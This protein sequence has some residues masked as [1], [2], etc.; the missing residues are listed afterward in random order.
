MMHPDPHIRMGQVIQMTRREIDRP[1]TARPRGP[2]D[3]PAMYRDTDADAETGYTADELLRA[4][5]RVL[6][7]IFTH[8]AAFVAGIVICALKA[9]GKI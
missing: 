7:P 9:T 4:A 2:F 8:G 6:W 3:A 5:H 1:L